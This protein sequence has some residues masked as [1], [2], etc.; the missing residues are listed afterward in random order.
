MGPPHTEFDRRLPAT[1]RSQP[2]AIDSA[3]EIR[4]G[5]GT[6][7]TIKN[8]LTFGFLQLAPTRADVDI[9]WQLLT[10]FIFRFVHGR[11]WLLQN[12][13]D[14][15]GRFSWWRRQRLEFLRLCIF[16]WFVLTSGCFP[17]NHQKSKKVSQRKNK[18]KKIL[19]T[20]NTCDRR[21]P[22]SKFAW[23]CTSK[24]SNRER[25]TTR[26]QPRS[27]FR[28]K[29]SSTT[30]PRS[31]LPFRQPS[32]R[33]RAASFPHRL[34]ERPHASTHNM[35]LKLLVLAHELPSHRHCKMPSK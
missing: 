13:R 5:L 4:I 27:C 3:L 12:C 30:T 33:S 21:R 18:K 26:R 17:K 14:D 25:P 19:L 10:R 24:L 31:N 32:L 34:S 20:W 15:L 7:R 35:R 6:G 22:F 8:V 2:P 28:S 16:R 29:P 23:Q 9:P 1:A 11:R